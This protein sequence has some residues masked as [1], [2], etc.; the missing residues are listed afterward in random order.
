MKKLGILLIVPVV[1]LGLVIFKTGFSA[2]SFNADELSANLSR[3]WV[4]PKKVEPVLKNYP[5]P[6]L[7]RPVTIAEGFEAYDGNLQDS[8]GDFHWAIDYVQK[9]GEDFSS[10]P[11]FSVH[12]G[13]VFQ[14]EGQSWGKFVIIRDR[15]E[16]DQGYNTL[17]AHLDNIPSFIPFMKFDIDKSKGISLSAGSYIGQASTTGNAKGIPQLHFEFHIVDLRTGTT[18]RADPYGVYKRLS[19]G[20]YPQPGSS[21]KEVIHYWQT[22]NPSFA[23]E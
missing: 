23:G 2:K 1:F 20:L 12:D 21:L 3:I 13:V 11:V 16:V 7:S 22:D 19:S 6:L 9:P 18:L 15:S 10:F 5:F 14:G 4:Q 8:P 17:Y